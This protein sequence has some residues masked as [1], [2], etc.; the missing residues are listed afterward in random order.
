MAITLLDHVNLR[1]AKLE[2]MTAFY[3]EVLGFENGERPPFPFGGA[4]LYCGGQATVHLVEI[5]E[6]LPTEA[7]KLEHFA[8]Q[9]TGL[10]DF[11]ARLRAH[12]VAYQI[13]VVPGWEIRQVNLFDPDGNHLHVDFDRNEEAELE[14]YDGG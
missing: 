9:A 10:A 12:K 4:W 7:P 11:L 2:A 3:T 13:A 14:N 1:T 6:D 5:P 8:F